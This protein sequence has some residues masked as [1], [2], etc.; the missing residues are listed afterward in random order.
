MFPYYIEYKNKKYITNAE[1][2]SHAEW[3]FVEAYGDVS[4]DE[5]FNVKVLDSIDRFLVPESNVLFF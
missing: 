1:N 2:L 3:K 5:E 4:E